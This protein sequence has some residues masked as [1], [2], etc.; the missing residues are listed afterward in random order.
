MNKSRGLTYLIW[1]CI[2]TAC[3]P[4]SSRRKCINISCGLLYTVRDCIITA[5]GL[6]YTLQD[7]TDIDIDSPKQYKSISTPF[8]YPKYPATLHQTAPTSLLC[9]SASYKITSTSFGYSLYYT[10][11]NQYRL[12]SPPSPHGTDST[13]LVP[14]S[15]PCKTESMSSEG[16]FT[17]YKIGSPPSVN[18]PSPCGTI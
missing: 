7:Y 15:A 8:R 11:L 14:S 13:P 1:S 18:F 3:M 17:Q 5:F 2:N 9:F 6:L 12:C 10:E 4:P 16:F